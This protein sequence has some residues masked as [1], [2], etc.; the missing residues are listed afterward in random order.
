MKKIIYKY[1]SKSYKLLLLLL[2]CTVNPA[3][4]EDNPPIS[5]H[6]AT[7]FNNAY[8][9]YENKNYNE[10]INILKKYVVEQEKTHPFAYTI[11]ALAAVEKKQYDLAIT[12]LKKA[13]GNYPKNYGLKHNY[14][15]ALM[16][17]KK[18]LQA[19]NLF[20]ELISLAPDEL[21]REFRYSAAQ[22]Y[23]FAKKYSQATKVGIP[24]VNVAKPKKAHLELI[25]R[26]YAQVGNLKEANKYYTLFVTH[27]P[28][29][30]QA[31]S[32]LSHI[33]YRQN[34][35][36]ASASS[37][38]LGT[39]VNPNSSSAKS[40]KENLAILYSNI[41]AFRLEMLTLKSIAKNTDRESRY[42]YAISNSS[43]QKEFFSY[44]NAKIEDKPSAELYFLKGLYQYR[45]LDLESAKS[46]FF[47]GHKVGGDE[48][49]R[50]LF[51]VALIN[52]EQGNLEEAFSYF[53]TLKSSK[54]FGSMALTS[55]A[56]IELIEKEKILLQGLGYINN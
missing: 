20:V 32:S 1:I 34:D 50:C 3:F 8:K 25:A 10:V 31:W 23:F 46:S 48:A 44:I 51:L 41:N 4:A 11:Y 19:A 49:E 14:A 17:A 30:I 47:Q 15:V 5:A 53:N 26:I 12:A 56:A 27:Y 40:S 36:S 22:A 38:E 9:V 55:L 45:L 42:L 43:N 16:S 6:E 35:I 21:K 29:D 2:L 52:W 39:R 28:T 24:L 7:I 54:D 33:R 37:L 18:Y 13:V